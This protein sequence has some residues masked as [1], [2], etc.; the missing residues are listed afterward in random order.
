MSFIVLQV[1]CPADLANK[2]KALAEQDER[3]VSTFVRRVLE[4]KVTEGGQA[5]DLRN[6]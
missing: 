6:A 2:V 1:R 4:Q 3:S 5:D